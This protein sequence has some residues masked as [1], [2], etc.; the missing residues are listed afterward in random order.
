MKRT[1]AVLTLFSLCALA[2]LGAQEPREFCTGDNCLAETLEVRFGTEA[3]GAPNVLEGVN[4]GDTIDA[5]V[6]INNSTDEIKGWSFGVAHDTA[7][8][9]V[10]DGSVTVDGLDLP[11]EFFPPVNTAAV[12]DPSPGIVSAFVAAILPP[13]GDKLQIADNIGLVKMQYTVIA[14]IPEGGTKLE[15]VNS[16]VPNPGAPA[17]AVNFTVGTTTNVPAN[18]IDGV[19]MGEVIVGD[20]CEVE[21]SDWAFYFG[22]AASADAYTIDSDT[23]VI[24]MRNATDALGF[25]MGVQV[26]GADFTFENE[27]VGTDAD[28]LIELIIT[29]GEG[30]SQTPSTNA[31]TSTRAPDANNIEEVTIG[32]SL[33]A[34]ANESDSFLAV[35]TNPGVGGP[36][37]TAG[38]VVDVSGTGAVIPATADTVECPVHEILVVKL[39]DVIDPPGTDFSR[40]DCNGD[41][42][43]NVTDGVVCA[44]NIFLNNLVFFDCD[45]MLDAN[46]DETLDAADPIMILEW[47]FLNGPALP[48]PFRTCAEDPEGDTLD[49]AVSNCAAP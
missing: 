31:A 4:N 21:G 37:F 38:Y 11:A 15:F 2:P 3:A 14:P 32:A 24:S 42:K 10:V 12:G 19:I 17:T 6:A 40:G 36:G 46:D 41:G 26:S 33:S 20:S 16:L 23:F 47:I 1:L 8:L 7:V 48:D 25:S 9:A 13:P 44:Q 18:V 28:R 5:I 34:I 45:D 49:C 29:D 27:V 39:T 22:P 35:D 30:A 43:I